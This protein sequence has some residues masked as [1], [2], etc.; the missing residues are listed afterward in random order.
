MALPQRIESLQKRHEWLDSILFK[1]LNHPF[2]DEARV[3]QIKKSKLKVK[4]EI[5]ALESE[6]KKLYDHD[7]AVFEQNDR[8]VARH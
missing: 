7:F 6:V 2:H 8:K 3:I 4:D 1:E 5:A